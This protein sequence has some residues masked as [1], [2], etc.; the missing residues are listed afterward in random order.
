MFIVVDFLLIRYLVK[1]AIS[2]KNPAFA[3]GD[4][5]VANGERNVIAFLK[6]STT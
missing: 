6:S 3:L 4:I 1:T 2:F 5:R